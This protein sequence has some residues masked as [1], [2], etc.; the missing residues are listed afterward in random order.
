MF[1]NLLDLLFDDLDQKRK[2]FLLLWCNVSVGGENF[3][4][5][6][7]FENLLLDDLNP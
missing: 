2:I 3:F 6:L 5:I 4:F 1:E 7:I